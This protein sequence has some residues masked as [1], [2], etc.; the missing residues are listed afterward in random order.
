MLKM[1]DQ[2][3]LDANHADLIRRIPS[4]RQYSAL[5]FTSGQRSG[6]G[7]HRGFHDFRHSLYRTMQSSG[8]L[9]GV[10]QNES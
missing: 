4:I 3:A 10:E 6:W 5:L 2:R 9:L 7:A 8:S 1:E